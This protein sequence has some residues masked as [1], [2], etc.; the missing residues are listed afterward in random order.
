MIVGLLPQHGV[1][2]GPQF[3]LC[4]DFPSRIVFYE[5][6]PSYDSRIVEAY[7]Y[8]LYW[9]GIVVITQPPFVLSPAVTSD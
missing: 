7:P 3:Y 1:Y 2:N 4:F 9:G 8:N 6:V 5:R